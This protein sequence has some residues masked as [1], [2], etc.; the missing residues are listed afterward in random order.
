MTPERLGEL[1][2]L[3]DGRQVG[4]EDATRPEDGRHQI[5]ETPGLGQ[6]ED[7]AIHRLLLGQAF[8]H[9]AQAHDEVR[10]LAHAQV[11]IGERAPAEVLALLVAH[12]LALGA[13][14]AK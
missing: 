13:H 5:H 12:D 7:R 11:D 1:V 10:H 4:Q 3:D 8:L 6:V 14:R 2:R 9:G